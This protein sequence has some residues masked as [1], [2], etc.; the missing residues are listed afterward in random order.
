M[1]FSQR[2]GFEPTEIPIQLNSMDDGLRNGL[3]DGIC[4]GILNGGMNGYDG[5]LDNGTQAL[6]ANRIWHNYWK[7]PLDRRPLKSREF[8]D[9]LRTHFLQ[10]KWNK[11][12]DLIEFIIENADRKNPNVSRDIDEMEIFLNRVLERDNSGF[13]IAGHKF[14]DIIDSSSISAISEAADQAKYSGAS[15]HIKTAIQLLFNRD[16][17]D[18]RNSIKESI[19]AVESACRSAVNDPKATLGQILK[20]MGDKIHPALR[21]GIS[22]IYGYTSDQEGIR[23]AMVDASQVTKADAQL[24]LTI[25][26]GIVNFIA[27]TY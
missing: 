7:L 19:S 26:S 12:Y 18:Y 14:I 10:C 16:G 4:I 17:P 8:M 5:K 6:L 3:W 25:C 22:K 20:E 2:K 23:H 21:D 9:E 1:N 15:T 11:A 24:M 13:R 27:A